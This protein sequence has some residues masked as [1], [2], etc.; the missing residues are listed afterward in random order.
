MPANK[1]IDSHMPSG[2]PYTIK[3]LLFVQHEAACELDRLYRVGRRSSWR[4]LKG[5]HSQACCYNKEEREQR[6]PG[7]Y[8]G[9]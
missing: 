2:V 8:N 5:A 7:W 4:E 9:P 1:W 3:T 6:H